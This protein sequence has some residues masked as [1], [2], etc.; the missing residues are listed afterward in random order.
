MNPLIQ[1]KTTPPLLITLALLCFGL[2]PKAQAVFPPPD[3]GYPGSNTAEGDNAL[4]SLTTGTN[5]TAVGSQSLTSDTTGYL[6]TACGAYALGNNTSGSNNT[7]I[8]GGALGGNFSGSN[9]TAIGEQALAQN[10]IGS[11]N[12]AQGFQALAFNRTGSYNTAVGLNSLEHNVAGQFNAAVGAFALFANTAAENTATG[13]AALLVNTTGAENTATGATALLSNTTGNSNTANGTGALSSNTTGS[14]NSAVGYEALLG[15]TTGDRNTACGV[16]ALQGNTTGAS[17][18][19]LGS[20]AGS[21][22]TTGSNNIEIG[23]SGFAA[24]HDTI[25]IGN[26][27]HIATFIDGIYGVSEGMPA[28]PVFVSSGGQ[29]GTTSSSRRFKNDI[30]AMDKA[31][32]AILALK[33]VTFHYNNDKTNTA[34]FGL[35]AEEVE[36]VNPDLIVRSPD[37]KPYTVRYDAVNAML[38]NEFLK[39][40]R[41][42]EEQEK[43]IAELKSGMTVL[44]AAVKEQAAQIQKVSALLEASKAGPQMV[45]NP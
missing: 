28:L 5:N 41:K 19:A 35:V 43:T 38:L 4:L 24:E 9:N 27:N 12:T 32:E 3:G 29:L 31:S 20:F 15:N 8:G 6:N 25:R 16:N 34:Q 11:S 2:L 37:G 33:P 30:K 22:L 18:I 44:S 26:T 7:G 17:N 39:E 45:N 1:L 13:A 40:H 36:Q 23:H 21:N 42:N 14:N 10:S